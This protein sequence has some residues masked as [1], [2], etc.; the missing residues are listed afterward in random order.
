VALRLTRWASWVT[1]S[2]V[3]EV[4]GELRRLETLVALRDGERPM[5][6][7]VKRLGISQPADSDHLWVVKDA[8]VVA[9]RVDAQCR[10]DRLCPEPIAKLDVRLSTCRQIWADRHEGHL[11]ERR[12]Q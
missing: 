12:V 11:N 8:G 5:D 9:S 7:N 6:E 4:V 3:L 10:N 1:T 2:A